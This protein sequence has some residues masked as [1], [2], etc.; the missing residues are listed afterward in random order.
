MSFLYLLHYRLKIHGQETAP[1]PHLGSIFPLIL[2]SI[3]PAVLLTM[4]KTPFDPI[5]LLLFGLDPSVRPILSL[6]A[7]IHRFERSPDF[8]LIQK[9]A[10]V[11]RSIFLIGRDIRRNLTELFFVGIYM[12]SGSLVLRKSRV[13]QMIQKETT[14]HKGECTLSPKL[15]GFP[16]F[17]PL[18]RSD[19]RTVETH[20]PLGYPV[21]LR[22]VHLP[23]LRIDLFRHFYF[24]HNIL[25]YPLSLG[26]DDLNHFLHLFQVPSHMLQH[27]L[28]RIIDGLFGLFLLFGIVEIFLP[29]H[30]GSGPVGFANNFA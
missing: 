4:T 6:G 18:D 28:F 7:S 21:D 23:L 24:A 13:F 14:I 11:P 19:I 27:L 1:D 20:Y 12:L 17:S 22:C 30:P 29:G 10:V 9:L 8:F 26:F 5:P 16:G 3:H 25:F 2:H 15:C